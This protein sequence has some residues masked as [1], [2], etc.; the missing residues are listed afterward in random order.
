MWYEYF[1]IILSCVRYNHT[2]FNVFVCR[3]PLGVSEFHIVVVAPAK[4]ESQRSESANGK[5][6]AY[7]AHLDGC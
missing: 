2:Y 3:A 5:A 7:L 6:T 4:T 1:K